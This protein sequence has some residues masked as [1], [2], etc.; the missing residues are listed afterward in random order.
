MAT[1][2]VKNGGSD[3]ANGL[4]DATA[5]AHHPWMT[6]WTA[7]AKS[8]VAGDIVSLKCGD[9]WVD[10]IIAAQNGTSGNPITLTSYGTGNKPKISGFTTLS[11]WT[12]YS[13][14]VYY[15]TLTSDEQTNFVLVDNVNTGMGR[16][17]DTGYRIF[18]SYN[19]T[20]FTITDTQLSEETP[21]SWIG[22]ELCLRCNNWTLERKR[23]TNQS[24]DIITYS[25]IDGTSGA[26][27][28]NYG[29]FIQNDLRTLTVTNEWYHDFATNR[30]YI[31]GNP[32]GKTI[33]AATKQR[34][35]Y[36]N[37]YDYLTINNIEFEGSIENLIH[38]AGTV[39]GLVITNCNMQYSGENGIMLIN[40]PSY[41]NISNNTI[42]D[43][44]AAG[45]KLWGGTENII[46]YNSISRSG[47]VLGMG[48]IAFRHCGI[49]TSGTTN[50]DVLN[51][52]IIDSASNGITID[53][54]YNLVQYN[55]VENASMRVNDSG[56][57]YVGSSAGNYSTIDHNI[58]YNVPGDGSGTPYASNPLARG[59]YVD[60]FAQYLTI[61]N[62]IIHTSTESS[63]MLHDANDNIVRYNILYNSRYGLYYLSS[64]AASIRR[65]LVDHNQFV[66]LA[67]TQYSTFAQ[68]YSGSPG[69]I[70]NFGT[71]NYNIYA[72]PI[73][74]N[75]DQTHLRTWDA[76][77]TNRTLS[78]W[79][80]FTGH[81][82]N[83]SYNLG[84]AISS[85]N[86]IRLIF[87]N[88][89]SDK[90]FELSASMKGLDNTSYSGTIT[91]EPFTGLV[92][93]GV[94][95]VTEVEDEP[96][97]PEGYITITG[98]R[99]NKYSIL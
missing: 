24:G 49:Y 20:S 39:T 84:G 69:D 27:G 47:M 64:S 8:L 38:S 2:Y 83:S 48:Y 71:I 60:D 61:T 87:N 16:W 41:C 30:L 42:S 67:S 51:N 89:M 29:Y 62:N 17:P 99:L 82:L 73:N 7:A 65:N 31:Y 77:Y 37:G 3:S 85:T 14:N 32:Y 1:Y 23:I 11:S 46:S 44:Q 28:N 68:A 79:Q 75:T 98:F 33:K 34:L 55:Y 52:I 97:I 53:G 86:D 56:G 10:K 54:T 66:A 93:L 40:T 15:S 6:G 74:Q 63:M 35:F 5:W 13:G 59:L 58:I 18:E 92:L 50:L 95:T 21:Y 78:S 88:T 72:R 96:P 91:L 9:V 25:N 80:S 57:I 81:D 43:C 36:T 4:T 90:Y 19:N 94:G 70:T 22:A 76:S 26:I 45:I 12:L